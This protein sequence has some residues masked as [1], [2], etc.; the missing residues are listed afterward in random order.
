MSEIRLP[1]YLGLT[2]TSRQVGLILAIN[3]PHGPRPCCQRL[4]CLVSCANHKLHLVRGLRAARARLWVPFFKPPLVGT[5]L[6]HEHVKPGVEPSPTLRFVTQA[7][8]GVALWWSG[9]GSRLSEPP[10]LEGLPRR[11][12]HSP[13]L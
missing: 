3:F 8:M 13:P 2:L 5:Y 7:T 9:L 10:H 6:V 4:L 12:C 11:A 1:Y